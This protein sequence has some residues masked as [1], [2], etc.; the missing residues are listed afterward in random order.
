MLLRASP[1]LLRR[2]SAPNVLFRPQINVKPPLFRD[3]AMHF[4]AMP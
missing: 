1:R 2:H 3:L 4:L